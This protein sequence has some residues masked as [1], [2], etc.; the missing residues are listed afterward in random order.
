MAVLDKEDQIVVE[1]NERC[2][3]EKA[4]TSLCLALGLKISN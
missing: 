2:M 1:G 4:R 3:Q